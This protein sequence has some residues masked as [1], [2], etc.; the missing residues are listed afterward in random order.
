MLPL[1]KEQREKVEANMGLVSGFFPR[2]DQG[3]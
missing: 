2:F 1:T 3:D